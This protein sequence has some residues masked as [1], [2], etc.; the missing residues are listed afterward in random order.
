MA[1]LLR[2]RERPING[3]P[4]G[5]S[6]AAGRW[7][8]WV[9]RALGLLEA[10]LA[11]ATLRGMPDRPVFLIGAFRSGTTLVERILCR[12][13][14]VASFC[15]FSNQFVRAPILAAWG[16]RMLARIGVLDL[17]PQGFIHNPK[18]PSNLFSSFE[19]EWIYSQCGRSLW[20][21]SDSI[22][23]GAQFSHPAFERHLASLVRRHVWLFGKR[24]FVNKNPYNSLRVGFLGRVFPTARFVR[25]VRHPLATIA[26]HLHTQRTLEDALTQVPDGRRIYR[27]GLHMDVLSAP[28]KTAHHAELLELE[29]LDRS[30]A[31]AA[32]WRDFQDAIDNV[33]ELNPSLR[34]R[35]HEIRYE[36][37]MADPRRSINDLLQQTELD[38]SGTNVVDA[39]VASIQPELPDPI[40]LAHR[41]QPNYARLRALVAAP[42][43]RLGYILPE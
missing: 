27:D 20:D 38:A 32:Q 43:E 21:A 17:Q 7:V 36:D 42:A 11:N 29:A 35:V 10:P 14:D 9:D 30:L 24:R 18:L 39:S 23:M 5:Y 31:L 34:T 1:G 12:H 19:C 40:Q 15:Y 25:V 16:I 8:P 3:M 33:L 2:W 41:F 37:L 4:H 26:S 13:P 22:E 6:L 28:A